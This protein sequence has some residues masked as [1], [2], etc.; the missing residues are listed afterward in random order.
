V[1]SILTTLISRAHHKLRYTV[2]PSSISQFSLSNCMEKFR[3]SEQITNV[4]PSS[5][6]VSYDHW[7]STHEFA[8]KGHYLNS[9]Q[10]YNHLYDAKLPCIKPSKDSNQPPWPP[11]IPVP[12]LSSSV[13]DH[14]LRSIE[15]N[16]LNFNYYPEDPIMECPSI[17]AYPPNV[18]SSILAD[19]P[20]SSPVFSVSDRVMLNTNY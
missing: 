20:V 18:Q 19:L 7:L 2:N 17:R 12:V 16:Q 14:S 5:K 15:S 9:P 4:A 8:A 10:P 13:D 11:T 6:V 3:Y 1:S